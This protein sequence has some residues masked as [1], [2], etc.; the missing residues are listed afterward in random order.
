[1]ISDG[2]AVEAEKAAVSQPGIRLVL[3]ARPSREAPAE[4]ISP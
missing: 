4:T 3:G 1:M 2:Q